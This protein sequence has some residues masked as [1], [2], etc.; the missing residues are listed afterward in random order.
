MLDGMIELF[1][2]PPI[3]P[4]FL[5]NCRMTPFRVTVLAG[6]AKKIKTRNFP[7]LAT[8]FQL[9]IMKRNYLGFVKSLSLNSQ[10]GKKVTRFKSTHTA[11][12]FFQIQLSMSS[13]Q[14]TRLPMNKQ[15]LKYTQKLG[16]VFVR[17]I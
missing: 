17:R 11:A 6:P 5:A 8:L 1:T 16:K 12:I 15:T 7:S 2:Y 14:D 10:N 13:F 4:Q 3:S 9:Y